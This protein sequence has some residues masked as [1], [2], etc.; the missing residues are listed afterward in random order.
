MGLGKERS[1]FGRYLD[2]Q[3]ITQSKLA[4]AAGVPS[5]TISR[6]AQSDRHEPSYSVGR[7]LILTLRAEG[8]AVGDDDFWT[9]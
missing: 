6:L 7:R 2:A 8:Y 3:S 5:S 9:S 1:K 4:V